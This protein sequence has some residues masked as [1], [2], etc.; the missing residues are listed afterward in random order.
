[1]QTIDNHKPL[2]CRC[3]RRVR[4]KWNYVGDCL[5]FIYG[6]KLKTVR[7]T[8]ALIGPTC[9]QTLIRQGVLAE[10]FEQVKKENSK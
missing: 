9:R 7:E 1:M 6:G 4:P 2:C 10:A 8:G 3:G 5:D